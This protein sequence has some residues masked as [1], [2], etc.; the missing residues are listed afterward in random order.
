MKEK[1]VGVL[2][3]F[4]ISLVLLVMIPTT[5]LGFL[6]SGSTNIWFFVISI[7]IITLTDISA[8]VLNNYAD[9]ELDRLNK[10]REQLHYGLRRQDLLIV[11]FGTVLLL[12]IFLLIF[13]SSFYLIL[14]VTLFVIL[15]I[16]YS[17]FLNL[18]DKTPLNY[19]AIGLSY[20]AL[21]FSIGF[22]SGSSS[23]ERYLFWSPLIIFLSIVTFAYTITKDYVDMSGDS[24]SGK[25]TLPVILGKKESV[26]VQAALEIAAYLVLLL[27]IVIG[28]L[29]VLF[30]ITLISLL[31]G[32][33]L[34]VDIDRSNE[35]KVLRRAALYNKLNH[36]LLRLLLILALVLSSGAL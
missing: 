8:N 3:S 24:V 1:I 4:I 27:F 16:F 29:N 7:V 18:K 25:N 35:I 6:A 10:K 14:S 15:G 32:I 31:F 12:Y 20:G 34:L 28:I 5:I 21:A 30:I 19:I 9:W 26:K 33:F 36:L 2:H 22:F 13:D 23:L 17:L 11:Y